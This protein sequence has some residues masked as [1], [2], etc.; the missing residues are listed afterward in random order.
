MGCV[1]SRRSGDSDCVGSEKNAHN[2]HRTHAG[3]KNPALRS[4]PRFGGPRKCSGRGSACTTKRK[5]RSLRPQGLRDD[6]RGKW[7][8]RCQETAPGTTDPPGSSA[9]TKGGRPGGPG[10]CAPTKKKARRADNLRPGAGRGSACA[11]KRKSRSLRPQGLR[12]DNEVDG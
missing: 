10:Y 8:A 2:L 11:T 6:T 7:A 5:S 12:D 1:P 4:N 3:L 9:N